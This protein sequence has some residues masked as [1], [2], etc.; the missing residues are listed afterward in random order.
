MNTIEENVTKS[1]MYDIT[2]A[3]RYLAL[4]ADIINGEKFLYFTDP[5]YVE[6]GNPV[7]RISSGY[8]HMFDVM[9]KYFRATGATFAISGGDWLNDTN[10]RETAIANMKDIDARMRA[11]FGDD[12]YLVVGNHDHNYQTWDA[13]KSAI[14][15]SPHW[16]TNGEI[17]AAWYSDR[18]YGGKCYYSFVGKN[19][20]F[21]VFRW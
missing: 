5:H 11:V 7:G 20:T 1:D 9:G 14:I 16:L 2:K 18:R 19:T 13:D 6:G 15:A 3:E 12:F 8:D 10:T 17:N 21:Y 4:S